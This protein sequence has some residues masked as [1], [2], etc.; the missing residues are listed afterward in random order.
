MDFQQELD[1]AVRLASE[2]N[3]IAYKFISGSTRVSY[4]GPN[5]PVTEADVRFDCTCCPAQLYTDGDSTSV[6]VLVHLPLCHSICRRVYIRTGN[7]PVP[8]GSL[9]SDARI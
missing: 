8:S 9:P 6:S 7:E 2:S 5:D 3:D 4:K 1:V